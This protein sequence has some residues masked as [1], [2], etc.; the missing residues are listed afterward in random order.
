MEIRA[1]LVGDPRQPI[2]GHYTYARKTR[3]AN[4]ETFDVELCA[5]GLI[6][7]ESPRL[8]SWDYADGAISLF[9]RD[10]TKTA[11]LTRRGEG[12]WTGSWTDGVNFVRLL[13]ACAALPGSPI[14]VSMYQSTM[15]P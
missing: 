11:T 5:D 7:P 6:Y 15:C 10:D 13:R 1:K 4:I 9:A 14:V 2:A 8:F 3:E 12:D